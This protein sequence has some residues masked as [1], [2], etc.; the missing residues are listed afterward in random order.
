LFLQ[1]E[2]DLGSKADLDFAAVQE[3]ANT[4]G[5]SEAIRESR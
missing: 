2:V 5:N 1:Q 4:P 3:N